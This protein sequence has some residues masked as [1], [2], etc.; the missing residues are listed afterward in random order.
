MDL[1]IERDKIEQR[2]QLN[3]TEVYRLMEEMKRDIKAAKD[4]DKLIKKSDELLSK[5]EK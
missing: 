2:I 1:Q 3:K 4:L 5:I